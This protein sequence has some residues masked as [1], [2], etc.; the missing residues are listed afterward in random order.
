[1]TEADLPEPK[2]KSQL[3]RDSEELKELGEVLIKMSA[4]ERSQVPLTEPIQAA[5][6]L[7]QRITSHGAL[8]R[9][10]QYLG[11]LLREADAEPIRAAVEA[12][13]RTGLQSAAYFQRLERWRDRLLAEGDPAIAD[14]IVDFPAAD[15]NQLRQLVRAAR[16]EATEGSAPRSSRALFRYLREISARPT[17]SDE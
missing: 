6:E 14:F 17:A 4:A 3:K 9:Q 7:A 13:R 15:R 10:V 5:I 2:S 12:V 16:K 8:R 1:M 11:K